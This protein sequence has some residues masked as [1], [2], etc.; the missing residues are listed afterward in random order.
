MFGAYR[1]CSTRT[2]DG[3]FAAG[4]RWCGHE[5]QWRRR[6]KQIDDNAV[7]MVG[8]RLKA[9]LRGRD[10]GN[11]VSVFWLSGQV[12]RWVI[13]DAR[14]LTVEYRKVEAGPQVVHVG[15]YPV[16]YDA[17]AASHAST[18]KTDAATAVRSSE[19]PIDEHTKRVDGFDEHANLPFLSQRG[20]REPVLRIV[21]AVVFYRLPRPVAHPV[22]QRLQT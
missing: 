19:K 4:G 7:Q 15:G 22:D 16:E 10:S 8:V 6:W 13:A 21:S 9:L 20:Q 18:G 14:R 11:T 5:P 2:V 17:S 1:R 12:C 3:I